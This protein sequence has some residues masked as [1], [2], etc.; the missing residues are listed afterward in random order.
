MPDGDQAAGVEDTGWYRAGLKRKA[1]DIS[2]TQY[3]VYSFS[4]E[5]YEDDDWQHVTHDSGEARGASASGQVAV[6]LGRAGREPGSGPLPR[7]PLQY[8]GPNKAP[9]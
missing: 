7:H 8:L 1:A 6:R 9:A 2:R 3:E 5:G 4:D